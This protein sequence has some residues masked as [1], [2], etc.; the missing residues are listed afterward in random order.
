[1]Y[2]NANV[3]WRGVG[4]KEGRDAKQDKRARHYGA[5]KRLSAHGFSRHACVR[6]HAAFSA[7]VCRHLNFCV[8]STH[9]SS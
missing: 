2:R 1:M 5:R 6:S 7:S 3:S 4:P 8:P 9:C